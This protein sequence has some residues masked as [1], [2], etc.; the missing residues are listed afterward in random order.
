V[1]LAGA[2]FAWTVL[3][4]V[5]DWFLGLPLFDGLVFQYLFG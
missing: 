3:Y 1:A 2:V 5:F 4:G